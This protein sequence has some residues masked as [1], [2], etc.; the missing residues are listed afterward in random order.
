MDGHSLKRKLREILQE[1]STST[2]LND[3]DSYDYIY[4]AVLEFVQRTRC[5]TSTQSITT[6]ASQTNYTLSSD[7]MELYLT[8]NQNRRYVKYNN[9]SNDTFI[10]ERDRAGVVFAN[11]TTAV[12]VPNNFYIRDVQSLTARLTG[13]ATSTGAITNNETTLTDTAADFTNVVVGDEIHNTTDDSHGVVLVK[14]STTALVTALFDGT[15]NK[16][17]S[18]DAYLIV[19]QGRLELVLDPPPSTAG[20]TITVNYIQ[21][22]EPVY[23]NFRNYKI[24]PEYDLAIIFYAAWLYKYRDKEPSYGDT[25]YKYFDDK[26]R[27]AGHVINS[28]L[29][30]REFTVNMIKRAGRQGSI[31]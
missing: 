11:N 24:K 22:P 19:P 26:V 21:R 20:H 2:F 30:R 27:R 29:N 13:T 25:F 17:T 9:G 7:F 14:T 23:S 5:I 3:R 8:D 15:N 31:K 4:A 12:T 1:G 28:T 6:V 18:A 16:W 10:Y